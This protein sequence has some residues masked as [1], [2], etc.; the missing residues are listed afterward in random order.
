[1]VSNVAASLPTLKE[2]SR[3]NIDSNSNSNFSKSNG[4]DFLKAI[5]YSSDEFKTTDAQPE[6]EYKNDSTSNADTQLVTSLLGEDIVNANPVDEITNS[7][8]YDA[9]PSFLSVGFNELVL[10][11]VNNVISNEKNISN[12]S[13]SFIEGRTEDDS[14]LG[15]NDIP[16]DMSN[17]QVKESI[18]VVGVT[19][20]KEL[21]AQKYYATGKLSYLDSSFDPKNNR[22]TTTGYDSAV[23]HSLKT[24]LTAPSVNP[25][26]LTII[27]SDFIHNQAGIAQKNNGL[28][29]SESKQV[30]SMAPV[31]I[32][33]PEYLKNKIT[34][35]EKGD[36]LKVYVRNYELTGSS[37]KMIA[38][39]FFDSMDAS[40]KSVVFVTINGDKYSRSGKV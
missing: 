39:Y 2:E 26:S 19:V 32:T 11:D 37:K 30:Q 27:E 28:M 5:N 7:A 13:D 20:S 9:N 6:L 34:F 15:M 12:S 18:D 22:Y 1:M 3:I 24:H 38:K 10:L 36:D 35:I 23:I 40:G 21:Y 14:Y 8:G 29:L 4:Q 16:I 25:T 17:G 33:L 31:A